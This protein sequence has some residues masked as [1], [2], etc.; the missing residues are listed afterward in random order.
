SPYGFQ[1]TVTAG[2][3]S[4]LGR[5][6]GPAGNI[7]DFIQTDAAINRGNSGGALVDL[8]G[9]VVGINTW[10][11]S[12]TGGSVGLGFSIPINNIVRSIDDFIETGAVRYGW[13]GVSIR[14]VTD[15]I[16]E[17]LRLSDRDGALVHH[18][19]LDSPADRGDLRPGDFITEIN[20]ITVDSSDALV[21][22]VGELPVGE[23]AEFVLIRHGEEIEIAVRIAERESEREIANLNTRLWP[24]FSVF[25]L[26]EQIREDME[27]TD[28]T[29]GLLVGTVESR[30]P[31]AFAGLRVGDIVLSV[32][33]TP[34]ETMYDLYRHLPQPGTDTEL[35]ILRDG[36]ELSIILKRGD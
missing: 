29:V 20:G 6:G 4:A 22:E 36:T 7:S 24:G 34:A 2:I 13:L 15:E 32:E 28:E 18:V 30:T 25:P 10:I 17:D 8:D 26:N 9:K 12:Q 11:T 1:S 31:A 35:T 23:D 5:R 14:S 19:F 27:L 33:G 16:A 21:L 3:V